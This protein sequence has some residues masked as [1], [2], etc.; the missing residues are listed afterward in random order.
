MKKIYKL[1][2]LCCANCAAKIENEIAK[3]DGVE[4]AVLAFMTQK[5]TMDV[6]DDKV[7]AVVAECEKIIHKIEPDVEIIKV[8]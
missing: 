6:A 5:L 8:R 1:E 4:K 7:D 2:G 3:V